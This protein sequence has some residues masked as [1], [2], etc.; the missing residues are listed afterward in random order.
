MA[1]GHRKLEIIARQIQDLSARLEGEDSALLSSA[2]LKRVRAMVAE[3]SERLRKCAEGLD[4]VRMPSFIFEPANPATAGRIAAV[5]L[6]AQPRHSLA[7]ADDDRFYGSGV[8]ALYYRGSFGA[9]RHIAKT[10]SPIYVGKADPA[11]PASRT[12]VEQEDRLSR[13]LRDHKRSITK[14]SSTLRVEDFDY[15]A[16]VVQTG[17][18][19][20]AEDYLIEL[21]RPIWNNE[22]DICYG[23]G[24]HGD[25]PGTRANQRSPWDTLHPGREWAYRDSRMRN[26]RSIEQIGQEIDQHLADHPPFQPLDKI[27]R[28]FL[29]LMR[30]TS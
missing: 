22:V 27:V 16:L 4:P 19:T 1:K 5:A 11:D 14:A 20:S 6:I 25:D 23:F 7:G 21:F 29:Q 17:Y 26:A 18:Q 10:E 15:R 30:A 24:K 12:S 8:Y 3:T 28:T 13:R 9:Y 2:N